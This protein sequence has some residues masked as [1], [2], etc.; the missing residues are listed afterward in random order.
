MEIVY[1]EEDLLRYMRDAVQASD[2]A[3]VLLDSFLS[4]AIEVDIDAVSDGE[5]WLSAPSCSI[6]NRRVC[7]PATLPAHCRPTA[8]MLLCRMKCVSRSGRWRWSWGQ[9]P[10]ERAAGLAGREIYVIEVNPRA[11][12][13]VPFVSKCIGTSLAKV[14]ARCMAGQTLASRGLPAK[15]CRPT[16]ASKKRCCRL[17][18]FPVWIPILGPEMKSTGE[19]MGTGE[20]FAAAFAKAQLA[21]GSARPPVARP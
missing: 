1:R 6:L 10:D 3:P 15:S 5:K 4:A 21:A 13:T 8:S 2:D 19:V 16:T 9:G 11:S 14:A 7:T 17:T 12:R 20:T 18:S